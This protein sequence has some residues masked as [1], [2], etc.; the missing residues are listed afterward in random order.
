MKKT[1][2]AMLL[3]LALAG[4]SSPISSGIITDKTHKEG[5]YYTTLICGAYSSK[6]YCTVYIPI[7]NYSPPVWRFD[8]REDEQTGWVRVTEETYNSY[9]VGDYYVSR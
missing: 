1:L 5:Y 3:C 4:C 9:E 2:A 8:I 6:G 7:Q